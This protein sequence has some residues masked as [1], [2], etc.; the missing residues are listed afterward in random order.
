M[1]LATVVVN[2]SDCTTELIYI[3]NFVMKNNTIKY[4]GP[5][6]FQLITLWEQMNEQGGYFQTEALEALIHQPSKKE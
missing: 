4:M 1:M 3:F 2:F 5:S 6:W